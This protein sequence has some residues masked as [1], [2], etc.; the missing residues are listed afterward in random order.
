MSP[1]KMYFD[2]EFLE[3]VRKILNIEFKR[4][5]ITD[6]LWSIETKINSLM[7]TSAELQQSHHPYY[8]LEILWKVLCI[9]CPEDPAN[10]LL[11]AMT[12]IV[13]FIDILHPVI[14]VSIF[15]TYSLSEQGTY[16]YKLYNCMCKFF[17]KI[18]SIAQY[19]ILYNQKFV[20]I[21]VCD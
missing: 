14:T 4:F 8:E 16:Y 21:N 13:S 1:T 19:H 15:Q 12:D 11:L 10:R 3:M 6:L 17:K 9:I 2:P 20:S 5:N 18:I 7:T